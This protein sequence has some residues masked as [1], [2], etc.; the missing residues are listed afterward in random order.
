MGAEKAGYIRGLVGL[1]AWLSVTNT[2]SHMVEGAKE[3][4]TGIAGN[5]LGATGLFTGMI[6]GVL[7]VELLC[8]FE[9]Q[10]A[11]KIKMPE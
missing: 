11:L 3:A 9:K 2:S 1:A 5:E 10:D 7:S 6:I 8:F 4:F